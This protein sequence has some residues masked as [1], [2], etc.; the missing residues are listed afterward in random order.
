MSPQVL[1]LLA[2]DQLHTTEARDMLT[3]REQDVLRL[4]T[5]GF[6]NKAIAQTLLLSVRTIEAHLRNIFE[7]LDVHS[8]TEAAPWGVRNGYAQ[9]D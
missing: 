9:N 5:Q 1:M 8:R 6:T 3:E 2:R 4:L 7:K